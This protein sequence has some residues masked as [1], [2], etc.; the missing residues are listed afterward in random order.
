MYIL[1]L[2][3]GQLNSLEFS[4]YIYMRMEFEHILNKIRRQKHDPKVKLRHLRLCA[5][6]KVHRDIDI[7]EKLK[8]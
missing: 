1:F 3:T 2:Y 4:R 6:F 7:I 8:S 5:I